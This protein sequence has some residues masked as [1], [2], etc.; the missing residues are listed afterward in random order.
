M[1][2]PPRLSG[3]TLACLL[4]LLATAH[5]ASKCTVGCRGMHPSK[6]YQEGHTYVY[7]LDGTSE[8]SV[9][10][11]QGTA[12]L[13]LSA[14]VEMSVKPNCVHQLRLK[15]VKLNGAPA[16]L[17]DLEKYAVQFNY[18]DGHI[19]TEL[20]TE[21]GD[22]Q[23]SLNIKR[24][25]VSLFQSAVMEESGSTTHHETDVMGACLTEFNFRKDGDTVTVRKDRNLAQCSYRE[26]LN[27]GLISASVDTSAGM[28]SSPLLGSQQAIV[29]RFKQGILTEASSKELYELRPFSNGNAGAKTTVD[30]KLVLKKEKA[31]SPTAAVSLPKSLIFERPHPVP[32]SS[33]EAI[34]NALK[35]TKDEVASGVKPEAATKFAE[36][37][38][39]LRRSSK[40]DIMSVYQKIKQGA[41]FDKDDQKLFL[42]TLFR[43]G[44]GEAVEVGVDL[45]KNK[46]LSGL[47]ELLFYASLALVRH[48]NLPAVTAATSL[49]DQ[50]NLPRL[51]Y[52]GVGQVIGKYCQE[53]SCENVAEVKEAVHKIREK[54][55]NGKA[56]T[57]EQE[58]LVVSA[59]KALGNTQF[60][61]DATLQKLANIAADKNVRNRVRVA[62]LGA[63]PNRCSMKWKNIAF[64]VLA[65]REEDSEVRIKTYLA[66]V[67]CPCPHVAN[68]LKEVLD[69][70]TVNQVGSFIQTHLRNLRASTDPNK[71]AAKNQLGLIKPRTKF[72]EDFRKFSYNDELSYKLGAFGAGSSAES[73]VIYS[74]NSFVP[75]STSLNM[76]MDLFGRSFNFLE[77]ETRVENLDRVIER[78]LGPKGQLWEKNI[79][80]LKKSGVSSVKN[81]NE[82]I[83]ERYDKVVRGKR[84]VKQGELDRFAKNVHLRNNEVDQDLD[85]DLSVKLFGVELAYLSYQ[86]DSSK[87]TPEAIVDKVFENLEKGFDLVKNLNFDLQ[88]YLQFLDAELVYPTNLGSSLNLGVTGTSVLRMKTNGKLDIPAILKDPKNANFRIALDPSVSVT[89][90]GSMVVQGLDAESGM[91]LISTLHTASSTDM[92][93]SVLNGNGIDVN[94]GIPKKKQELISASSELLLSSGPKG[95]KY[96]APKFGKGKTHSDCFDQFS[97]LLG[98]TVCGQLTYPYED[99]ATISQKPMFP[100]SG[101]AKFAIT[102]ENNDVS[103]YHFRVNL[104][105]ESAAKRSFEI[106]V[107]TPNS[108]TN[109]RVALNLEAGLEPNKYAKV[110]LDSP[111]K[112]ASLEVILKNNPK[113]RTL[114]LIAFHDQI[115]YYGRI[116]VLASGGKY[117]PVLE[118]R[119][120]EHIEK[121]ATAKTGLKSGQQYT[122]QGTVDVADHQ[123]GQKFM[124]DKVALMVGGQKLVVVDGDVT[125]TPTAVTVDSSLS[126]SD[127]SLIFKLDGKQISSNNY[128]LIVTAIP[129]TDP[130]IGFNL[131]WEYKRE[132]DNL[133]NKLIFVHGSDPNSETNRLTLNQEAVYKIGPKTPLVLSMSNEL[134]YPALNMKLKV[135]GKLTRKSVSGDIEVK[136]EKFKFGTE[137][138]AKKDME[139]PGDYDIELEAELMENGVELKSKRTIVDAHKSKFSNS[140]V[141]KPGGKYEADATVTHDV[142]KNNINV[143]LDGDLNLNGKKVKMD[144]GLEANPQALNSRVFVK[145]DGVKYIE[146]LLKTTR[147]PNPS[148]SLTL[149]LKN[150]VTASG[151]YIYQN[152]KG[153]A[154]LNV[155]FPKINRK[156]KANADLAIS[157]SEH[158][159]N[160]EILYDAE[161][162]PSKRLKLSTVSDI[163]KNSVDTKNVLEVLTYKMELNGKGKLQGSLQDGQLQLDV[164][165]TLP[166]GRYLVWKMKRNSA[167]KDNKYDI[168][169]DTELVDN[170]VKGG[171][172]RKLAYKADVKDLDLEQLTYQKNSAQLKF[173]D[174]DGKDLQ[175]SWNGKNTLQPENKKSRELNVEV[176]GASIPR[177]F[178]LQISSDCGNSEAALKTKASLGDDISMMCSGTISEGNQVDKPSKLDGVFEMKLPSDK[179]SNLKLEVSSSLLDATEKNLIDYAENIKL[180]YNNDK[181][182]QGELSYKLQLPDKDSNLPSSGTGKLILNIL[183]NPPLKVD[184]KYEY[185][186]N[187]EKQTAMVDLNASYGDKKLSLRSDNEYLPD[188]ATVNLKA[189]GNML[190][191][192]LR[193]LN[194]DL[195]YQRFKEQNRLLVDSVLTADDNKYTLNSEIQQ[196]STNN[197]FHLTASSPLGKTEV[198]SKFQKLGDKEYKGEWKVDTPKGFAVADAHVDL[199]SVDNFVINANFDSDK[200]KHR[201]IHAE[202]ANKPTAKSG[203]RIVITVTSDGQNIVAGSTSYKKRDEDGKI[204]VEGNGSLKVGDDTKS[205]SFKYTR[206]QLTRE[207]DGEVGVAMV[208]NANFGPSAIVGELKLSN[209]EVHV[210]NSYCEQNKDCAHF[211]LQSTL[212]VEQKAL[213]K[214]QITV[215]VDLKKFNVPAEFGL[216][217]STE[218]KKPIFDHTTNLYLHS[219]KDKSEYTY[220]VYIH[221]K[222]AASILTLPS[223][224]IAAVATYDLPKTKHTGAYKVDLSIYLDRKNKPADKTSLSSSGDVLIDEN[225]LSL[226]G[227]TKFTYPTQPKGMVVKGSLHHSRDRLLTANLDIDV[228]AKKSQMIS[229]VAN[230]QRQP[231]TD[232]SNVTGSVEV[233]SRGQHLKLDLKSHLTLSKQQAGFGSFFSYS[234]VN[235]KMKTMGVLFS[236]D[237][238]HISL[239]ATLPDKELIRDDWKLQFAKNR[240]KIDRE[241]SVLGET[242]NV[243]T[244]EAN[245]FN[246]FNLQIHPKDK[247]NDKLS[248][249]G[250]AV[251]GQ[252]AQVHA[253]LYKNGA[254]KELFHVLVHLDE[255]QFL[256][257]DF[258]YNKENVAELL[259]IYKNR[260]IQLAMKMKDVHEYVVEKVKAET[261]DL[262]EHLKKA[263]P[264]LKPLM[265]Y[266]QGE[267]N[268]MKDDFYAD[269]TVKE[270]QATLNKYFGALVATVAETMKQIAQGLEKL[271]EQLNTIIVDVEKAI[272]RTYPELKASYNKIFHQVMEI[273]DAVAKL[274]NTYLNAILNIINEHQ[275]EIQDVMSVVSGMTQDFAKIIT[276]GLEQ[277]KANLEE[278]AAMLVNQLKALPIYE[279]AKEKYQ[280]LLNFQ[281]PEMVI[282]PVEEFCRV[283]NTALPTEELRQLTDASCQYLL[284]HVKREKVDEIAELKRLYS[285]AVTAIQSLLTLLQKQATFDNALNFVQIQSPIDFS[286][287]S[288]LPGISTLRLSVLNLLRNQELPSPLDLYYTYRPTLYPS[289]ILPPFSKS[290]VVTDGGHIFT[291]DG[292]H[293]TMPGT[294]N[295][296]LAQDME[297]G[298]FSVVAN[299]QGGNLISVTI[300]EPKESITLKNNGN[301]LVNNKPADFP[302]STKNLHAYLVQP[303]ANVKSDYGVR[304]TCSNKVPMICAVHVSG[305]YLGKL[306]G[307]FGDGN[308]EPYDDY[309]LPSGKITESSTEFGNAYKLKNECPDTTAVHHKERA[310]ICTEYFTSQSSSLKSCFNY[311]NPANY[312]EACDHAVGM[313]TP[314]NAC[315]IA[316][317][318]HYACY[319]QRVMT[320]RVPST[321]T[322]CKVGANKINIGDTFSVKVPKKEADI[323]FVV[324]QQTPNDKIY[325]ELVTPLMGELREELKQHGITDVHI[326]LI[327]F[328]ESM[329]WPQHY[330]LN[331]NTNIEGDVKNM[332]FSEKKP[333]VSMEEA[334]E[335]NT[336]KKI[337][338]LHQKLDIELGTFRLTDAYEE[339]IRYP[340]KPGAAK[341]VV[342][343]IANPCEK[344][345]FPISLQQIRLLLG[346]KMYR[347]LGLTYHHV[348][349]PNELL[350]S[351]KPQKNIVGYDQDYA[352]T[353]ADSKKKPLSG[354][355]DMKNNL[356]ATTNDVCADFAVSSGGAAFSSDNFLDAKPNQKKQFIQV[357]A[358]RIVDGLVNV[359]FE[360]DCSCDYQYGLIGRTQ[361][362]IV[363][364]KEAP[365]RSTKGV[366][367]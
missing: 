337:T 95:E 270:I 87:L 38:K 179:L 11:A 216:K 200:L 238:N 105:T 292:R 265:D 317:A 308:N 71:L 106:L 152:R 44:S 14:T 332:K 109:R 26:N 300:T 313:G 298:N 197:I 115:E 69:K 81:L 279:V 110:S 243:I 112:K 289:D 83:K 328:S 48:M 241:L 283:L 54:V 32:K 117:K 100:L 310:P 12:N 148:G 127:K 365:A 212:D 255:K 28:K 363:G 124:L 5:A 24:A 101:P 264:N 88:N 231:I 235:Q 166:N 296:I 193:N 322:S 254:K 140:L 169:V 35:A 49:L 145:V 153:N 186:P 79:E 142:S 334:K 133:Q 220:Q 138:S 118:Y 6:A 56:K 278:F 94:F 234:D 227:E 318:Y 302:A 277:I 258:G 349:Y 208:L 170:T 204:V 114:S 237:V 37:V 121:L 221:P 207:K 122:V 284:K 362:K 306:R 223:R 30:T 250:Q 203:K 125:I 319:A 182:M 15:N 158:V 316:T 290:A 275:K 331:G 172:S 104:N 202:I 350:V 225:N 214:H 361:C 198:L 266:Y 1:G 85:V 173:V 252:L 72:P 293:L 46:E 229:L 103:S 295:Y 299:L 51:G 285:Y 287:L 2:H 206:Q 245:D 181:K 348:S 55:G 247:P 230:V 329:K 358:R 351:G 86:G 352:Y 194:L 224:E 22:S 239:L 336:E 251:I 66:L 25:V 19:D 330:T 27:Q 248:V 312:R 99:L 43:T 120:P 325:K 280:E 345:P 33:V 184:G 113:E 75:R 192:K 305:F 116:G 17:P 366:K 347:D 97:T 53:H 286:L 156:V 34:T 236:A 61:D 20:C 273:L 281:I 303:F 246:R 211:K 222:E 355:S 9:T 339:A 149:N 7:N 357:A 132:P 154:N 129:S 240:Q 164:D 41:G 261:T 57:R 159:G 323:V 68:Q 201:K 226:S 52:L 276:K 324:E 64:K 93:V 119:V 263:E 161:K 139:K 333:S 39:V 63:L 144:T 3:T 288:K 256:K 42:D 21:P 180:T 232:G 301:I 342:G 356:V 102:V 282:S 162:D 314:E 137:L 29:Q 70:E 178:Q 191:E 268:K 80:E 73:N 271:R 136:Y 18:H 74:Q 307:L 168:L 171:P 210:F 244:F 146:F 249:N 354:S 77:L 190:A 346:Q 338:Y 215:E 134:T 60:L 335:G 167:K 62:A 343:V 98:L 150:Y 326:G 196:Q 321:C 187:S 209:K 344:S 4:L 151:Q 242:P 107:E 185:V 67:A 8:T 16:S 218:L 157:G 274:A 160:L 176:T 205:S 92:T 267:L 219:T 269:E 130:N 131:K 260:N 91:K 291:F 111:I 163:T 188:V 304:L 40:D 96:V 177:K 58:N 143:Q 353:F 155:D 262:V 360:K 340:F 341:A 183:Q 141:L 294:C 272:A 126:Y 31:D 253:D 175:V 76:T 90:I 147:T 174:A 165:T 213:L 36:L 128:A 257:P 311:V 50:P 320:T 65:D 315:I 297:D 195:K 78:Y 327:G 217:T 13:R 59:L 359:E 199:E 23:A 259:E 123:G 108:K 367:G 135:E 364:R 47:Q 10:D 89:I 82:Y 233:N 309:T 45:V 189:K 84:E 228:F